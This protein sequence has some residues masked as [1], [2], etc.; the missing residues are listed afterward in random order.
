MNDETRLL[1]NAEPQLLLESGPMKLRDF[2]PRGVLRFSGRKCVTCGREIMDHWLRSG[3]TEY[4]CH[5][6]Q[7]QFSEG[8]ENCRYDVP[9]GFGK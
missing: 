7:N 5:E 4:W 6:N 3:S 1:D 2:N 8:I 9:E